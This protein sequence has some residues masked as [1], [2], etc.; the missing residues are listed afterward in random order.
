[1][2]AIRS[3]VF[4]AILIAWTA[5][6]LPGL[7]VL[8]LCGRPTGAIR[9]VSRTWAKGVLFALKWTVGLT[10]VE[11]GRQNV[12]VGPCLI[13]ANHQ[14]QWET[15]AF[16]ILVPDVAIVAKQ[17]LLAIPVMGWFLRH[18]PMIIIDRDGGGSAV[19]HMVSE[20]RAALA[21][22][23]AVL[24]FPEGSRQS[25]DVK[26]AFKR[27]VELLYRQLDVPVLPIAL[28]SGS[29]WTAKE[30]FKRAGAITVS[31]L[32]TIQPGLPGAEFARLAERAVQE[33]LQRL[34][35]RVPAPL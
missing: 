30:R 16:L 17:E 14:S 5:M 8:F 29:F 21:Q 35:P 27:G 4:D 6:F 18:S 34:D 33:A 23:R 28:N 26:V 1:M 7:A 19:R 15:I 2:R 13:V 32:P 24:I 22:G 12:P 20:A 25:S 3:R 11:L 9:A 31:Y 10:Y